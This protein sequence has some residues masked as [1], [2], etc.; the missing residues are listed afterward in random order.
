MELSS[1][2][3]TDVKEYLGFS[4]VIANNTMGDHR[5]G[6]CLLSNHDHEITLQ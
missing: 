6:L 3:D 2:K 5:F 4:G 1:M